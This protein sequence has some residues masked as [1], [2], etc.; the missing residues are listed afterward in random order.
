VHTKTALGIILRD[1]PQPPEKTPG[2]VWW[3]AVNGPDTWNLLADKSMCEAGAA[4][5][6][7]WAKAKP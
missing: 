5:V 2:Q 7:A 1:H 6:L 3:E 4:A